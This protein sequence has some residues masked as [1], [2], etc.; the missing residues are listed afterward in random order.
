[1]A[2]DSPLPS[3]C[4]CAVHRRRAPLSITV[5]SSLRCPSPS[6]AIALE[7]HR[8]C[9]HAVPHR[10]SLLRSRHAVPCRRVTVAPSIALTPRHPSPLSPRPSPFIAVNLSIA[11]EL[12]SCHPLLPI[13]LESIAVELPLRHPLPPTARWSSNLRR[14]GRQH[15]SSGGRASIIVAEL[16]HQIDDN[17]VAKSSLLLSSCRQPHPPQ[18]HAPSLSLLRDDAFCCHHWLSSLPIRATPPLPSIASSSH[19]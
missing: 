6:I 3:S 7:V 4:P 13:T 14:G 5:E 1:M 10:P 12:P 9:A 16:S 8:H 11:V 17:L 2:Y 15:A 18:L 19:C